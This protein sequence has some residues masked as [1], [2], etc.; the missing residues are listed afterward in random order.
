V[1]LAKPTRSSTPTKST[2]GTS[3]GE[4]T[5]TIGCG[6][7]R[8]A[9]RCRSFGGREYTTKPSTAA[10]CTVSVLVASGPAGT[11]SSDRPVS[12]QARATPWRNSTALGSTKARERL[13]P[14]TRPTALA[15]RIRSERATGSGPW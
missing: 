14:K 3:R 2:S 4:S 11:R 15:V 5:I 9:A 8:T 13:S 12:S 6:R 7:V 10:R 1:I